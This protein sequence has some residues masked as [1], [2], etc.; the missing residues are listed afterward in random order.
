MG[1]EN[2]NTIGSRIDLAMKLANPKQ[3]DALPEA[4]N[5]MRRTWQ[6]ARIPNDEIEIMTEKAGGQ[7]IRTAREIVIS[8]PI[9]VFE[10]RWTSDR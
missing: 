2:P 7:L 3:P 8:P 5:V 6:D 1:P 10:K 4:I 9:P